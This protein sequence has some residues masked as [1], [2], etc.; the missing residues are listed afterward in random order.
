[1][2][3][4]IGHWFVVHDV[5]SFWWLGDL[6][7]KLN[8]GW[9]SILSWLEVNWIWPRKPC[10]G[11]AKVAHSQGRSDDPTRQACGVG[12]RG[13]C[14]GRRPWNSS[15]FVLFGQKHLELQWNTSD[16]E[17]CSRCLRQFVLSEMSG[18][19]VHETKRAMSYV[20]KLSQ[21]KQE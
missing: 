19:I 11:S 15:S 9:F 13:F 8:H 12:G 7:N 10:R 18:R 17:S 6:P 16:L 14:V 5:L 21:A 3:R 2:P 1:M 20:F 4:V